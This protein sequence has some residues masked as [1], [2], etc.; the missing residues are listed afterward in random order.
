V[1]TAVL[2]EGRTSLKFIWAA[3]HWKRY[4]P[5]LTPKKACNLIRYWLHFSYD[6]K[7]QTQRIK[8]II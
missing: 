7:I 6:Q 1:K 2:R 4:P 5:P 8:E 3:A